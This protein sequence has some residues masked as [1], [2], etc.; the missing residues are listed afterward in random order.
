MFFVSDD[1]RR[2]PSGEW[3]AQAGKNDQL[4]PGSRSN[5]DGNDNQQSGNFSK[6]NILIIVGASASAAVV[7]V[8]LVAAYLCRRRYRS[9]S[10]AGYT[11]GKKTG[12]GNAPVGADSKPPPD[13]WIHHDHS[14]ELRNVGNASTQD[15][16]RR[17]PS[18]PP[19]E[20]LEQPTPRY[21]SLAGKIFSFWASY[22][23]SF[24]R[25]PYSVK[26]FC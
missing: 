7:V 13:L 22:F 10:G 21:H 18:P 15:F 8:I 12:S 5:V 14:L 24:C 2:K 20:L 26:L 25:T 6:Q 3:S 23:I 1:A 16:K 19:T 17:T 11:A 4:T 9:R